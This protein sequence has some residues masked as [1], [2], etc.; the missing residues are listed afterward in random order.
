MRT[1]QNLMGH[2][3]THATVLYCDVSD[4]TLGNA[5]VPCVSVPFGTARPLEGR[6][7]S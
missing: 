1:I 3:R 2:R 4:A 7:V 6:V 5:V